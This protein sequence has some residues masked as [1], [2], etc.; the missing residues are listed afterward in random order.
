MKYI[1]KAIL[2]LLLI[3]CLAEMPYG[4]YQ[5]FRI[6]GTIMFIWL[7]SIAF[8]N[9]KN[10]VVLFYSLMAALLQPV[11]KIHFAREIWNAIDVVIAAVL[12]VIFIWELGKKLRHSGSTNTK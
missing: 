1:L 7:A 5:F 12:L 10:A 2:I 8:Q 9:K 11:L 4:Y 3:G 6:A